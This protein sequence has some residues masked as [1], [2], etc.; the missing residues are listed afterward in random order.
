MDIISFLFAPF[1]KSVF[2][3]YF[4]IIEILYF[5]FAFLIFI[6]IIY[7]GVSNKEGALFYLEKMLHVLVFVVIY[8]QSRLLHSMCIHSI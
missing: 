3:N 4:L 7:L 6:S 8:F 2:C 5:I 1:E